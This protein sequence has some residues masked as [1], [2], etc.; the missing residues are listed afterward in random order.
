MRR[1][2]Q[3][4]GE[5]ALDTVKIEDILRDAVLSPEFLTEK[6][7]PAEMFPQQDLGRSWKTSQF[8]ATS[9]QA[10]LSSYSAI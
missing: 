3:L 4:N 5:I 8:P 7:F 1:A 9:L 6:L 2:V 10:Y